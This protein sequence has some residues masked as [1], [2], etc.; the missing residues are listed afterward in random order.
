M[1]CSE[2]NIDPETF[3]LIVEGSIPGLLDYCLWGNIVK[4]PRYVCVCVCVCVCVYVSISVIGMY[5][6]LISRTNV[7]NAQ[8]MTMAVTNKISIG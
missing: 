3:N 8:G 4:D 7:N 2:D 6:S 1:E 5:S